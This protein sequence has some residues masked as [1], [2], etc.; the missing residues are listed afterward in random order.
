MTSTRRS[1]SPTRSKSP[2]ILN[3]IAGAVCLEQDDRVVN[4]R[5][6]KEQP[7]L[8]F[9]VESPHRV[10]AHPWRP[11]RHDRVPSLLVG[12]R[13]DEEN[14]PATEPAITGG[15]KAGVGHQ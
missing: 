9:M 4:A 13:V 7:Q 6:E 2:G 8:V 12:R 15:H 10:V 1:L 14:L 5:V 3:L 11:R